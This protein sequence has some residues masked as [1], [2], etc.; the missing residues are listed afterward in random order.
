[1]VARVTN[2]A[3]QTTA[4]HVHEELGDASF[5]SQVNRWGKKPLETLYPKYLKF[6]SMTGRAYCAK[7][8]FFTPGRELYRAGK[9]LL[10][11]I[12][13]LFNFSREFFQTLFKESGYSWNDLGKN[14]K[15]ILSATLALPARI[16][17]VILDVA[18]LSAGILVPRAAIHSRIHIEIND[19]NNDGRIDS[20]EVHIEVDP[21]QN[22]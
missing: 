7:E 21:A 22:S 19:D 20:D 9:N 1:M 12:E 4:T 15:D 3:K 11:I 13:K 14:V 5:R 10:L 2:I 8:L 6:S 17:T 18:K 16:L